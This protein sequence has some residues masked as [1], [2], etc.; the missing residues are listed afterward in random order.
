MRVAVIGAG[1]SGLGAAIALHG[2]ACVDVS[3][4][5]REPRA[6]GHAHTIDIAYGQTNV[7]V[8]T[9]FIVYNVLNYPH[10]TALFQWAGVDTIASDMS[11]ALSSDD[12]AFEWCG[13][14]EAPL[15]GL[16]AQ[17]SNAFD[18]AFYRFLLGI[19]Q[20]QRRAIRDHAAGTVGDGTLDA[21]LTRIACPPRVRDDYVVP[22][23]AAIWSMTPGET[24]AFPAAS[25]IAF[26]NNHK[27]LQWDRPTWRT[28]KG[29]SRGYV[30]RLEQQLGAALRKGEAVSSL[31]RSETGVTLHLEDGRTETFDAAILAT[32]APTALRLLGDATPRERDILSAFRVSNN[33]VVVHRDA[34]LMPKRKAAWASWNLLRRTGDSEAAVTYW[35]NRLQAIPDEIPLFVTLNPDRPVR[36]DLIFAQFNYDHPVYD[37]SAITAQ[38]RLAAFQDQETQDP[39]ARQQGRVLFAG[40]WTGYGFHEDGLR[41]GLAAASALGGLAPWLR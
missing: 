23:G 7:A 41:S 37:A 28:V 16:F 22:M 25:F 27:L 24:L 30:D 10:L 13:R 6:G 17:A 35:M 8:D 38:Q 32:H 31:Q 12:G 9:G 15:R 4:F 26:F 34:A 2:M 18:P 40:A 3:L 1:I 39:Q 33:V 36:E 19:R 21:Y 5:E 11:F 20:V 29:G 14:H